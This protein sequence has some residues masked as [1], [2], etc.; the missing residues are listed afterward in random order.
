MISTEIKL[1]DLNS[2]IAGCNYNICKWL[3]EHQQQG[4]SFCPRS[5]GKNSRPNRPTTWRQKKENTASRSAQLGRSSSAAL[6]HCQLH[7]PAH[8]TRMEGRVAV[9]A[10]TTAAEARAVRETTGAVEMG[11]EDE[12][13]VA[14]SSMNPAISLNKRTTRARVITKKPKKRPV[15]I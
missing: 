14:E 11:Q 10:M 7:L 12:G 8:R 15:D 1:A 9:I 6:G 5:R 3:K 13:R 4:L 2:I